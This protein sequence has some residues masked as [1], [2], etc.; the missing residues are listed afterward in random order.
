MILD[1][2]F[3]LEKIHVLSCIWVKLFNCLLQTPYDSETTYLKDDFG[4][5]F[6]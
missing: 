2:L 5:L 6:F 4:F 1:S 3:S